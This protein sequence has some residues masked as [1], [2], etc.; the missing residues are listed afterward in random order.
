MLPKVAT[1]TTYYKLDSSRF[2]ECM[3]GRILLV[4]LVFMCIQ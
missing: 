1:T 4:L 3:D 2:I